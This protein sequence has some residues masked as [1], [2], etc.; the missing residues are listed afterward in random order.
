MLYVWLYEILWNK[1]SH[2]NEIF[3]ELS[4]ET[5]EIIISYCLRLFTQSFYFNKILNILR[6]ISG[7]RKI[8][9]YKQY[10]DRNIF[11]QLHKEYNEV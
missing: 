1:N 6:K 8:E 2:R 3:K 4:F 5:K 11:I 9:A 7:E 10:K